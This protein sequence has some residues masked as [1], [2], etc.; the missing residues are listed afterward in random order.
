MQAMYPQKVE[1]FK[2]A[3]G[4]LPPA[5]WHAKS[6]PMS[7]D[8]Q[9][10]HIGERLKAVRLA[11][12]GLPQNQWAEKHNF[13][14]TQWNNWEKGARRIPVECAERLR[15]LYGLTLDCI[16]LGRR[17]GLSERASKVL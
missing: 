1:S 6:G 14:L 3:I 4:G 9:Y 10:L 5:L 11:F 2:C 17:D 16:Y 13:N 7:Q 8:A 15:Y 12:S